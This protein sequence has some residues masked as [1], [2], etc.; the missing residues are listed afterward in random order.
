MKDKEKADAVN[1]G[2]KKTNELIKLYQAFFRF[3]INKSVNFGQC[4]RCKSDYMNFSVNGYC[5]NC[6]QRVEFVNREH[7]QVLKKIRCAAEVQI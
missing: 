2:N 5:Q 4:I 7:P 1:I 6:I 3:D